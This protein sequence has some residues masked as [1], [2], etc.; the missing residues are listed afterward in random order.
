MRLHWLPLVAP[1]LLAVPVTHCGSDPAPPAGPTVD[2]REYALGGGG[3]RFFAMQPRI[4]MK[5]LTTQAEYRAWIDALVNERVTPCLAKD[6]PNVIA[7][8]EDVALPA[9]FLGSRA[10]R[11][12]SQSDTFGAF[13][14]VLAGYQNAA[15]YYDDR[16]TGLG[17]GEKLNLSVTDTVWR[18]FF[19]T[20]QSVAKRTG[21]WVVASANAS[22]TIETSTDDILRKRLGDPDV[23]SP[24]VYVAKDRAVYNTAFVFNPQGAIVFQAHK[25]YLVET[26]EKDLQLAY[27]RMRDVAPFDT[28][29]ARMGFL[30]SKDA[31]MPDVVDRL[32]IQGADTFIQPE[33]FSGWTIEELP[34]DWLPEVFSQSAWS[35]T[36]KHGSFRAAVI[37][38]LTGN[39][40][41][42]IFDGQAAV[43]VDDPGAQLGYVGM[44]MTGFRALAPW[45]AP[46]PG[47]GS[48]ADRRAA[49]RDVGN[50]LKPGGSRENQYVRTAVAADVD[51]RGAFPSVTA[52]NAGVFGAS[53]AVADAAKGEQRNVAVGSDG[54]TVLAAWEDTQGGKAQI[55]L[56]A[57]AAGAFA[58]PKPVA[59]GSDEQLTPSVAVSGAN[60]WLAWTEH[61][62][63]EM[64]VVVAHSTDG[65]ATFGAKSTLGTPAGADEWLPQI[66]AD[67]SSAWIAYVAN[68]AE[69]ERIRVAR[70]TDGI[71]FTITE[72]DAK[73]PA[74]VAPNTRNNQ[75]SP[76]LARTP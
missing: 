51:P 18:A 26:E 14:N 54:A 46:D 65:G 57:F 37:P 21:A 72:A 9:S 75:W 76:A 56:S 44:T 10:E 74:F 36:Q 16:L 39:L 43:I 40:F 69:N 66:V 62:A 34:G 33:A 50:A 38:H 52:G 35:A 1:L 64:R 63:T 68:D 60:V 17:F 20:M 55:Q 59:P 70:T 5:T 6:H 12:R 7:F 23:P 27:G 67:G 13:F 58:T 45:A 47:T 8:P 32:A 31:W 2:C 4:D 11:A 25:P 61:S 49:L 48:V 15:S 24:Y 19:E 53:H 41:D 42:Q 22:G 28:G 29:F 73:K 3:A 71:T 30:T